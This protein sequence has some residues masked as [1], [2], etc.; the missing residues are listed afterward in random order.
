MEHERELVWSEIFQDDEQGEPDRVGY[1]GFLFGR[2][3]FRKGL[4]QV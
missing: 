4:R 2:D 1:Q 3:N